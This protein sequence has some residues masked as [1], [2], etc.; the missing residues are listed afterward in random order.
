L[1]GFAEGE[2][3]WGRRPHILLPQVSGI[4]SGD[5]PCNF[6]SFS[7]SDDKKAGT[8]ALSSLITNV[9][10]VSFKS[11]SFIPADARGARG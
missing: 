1:P 10:I 3:E 6:P 4:K 2:V 5:I 8:T 9:A 7:Y 11:L